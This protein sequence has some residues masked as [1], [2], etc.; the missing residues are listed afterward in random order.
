M[1]NEELRIRNLQRVL[2]TTYEQCLCHGIENTTQGMLV[3]ASGLSRASIDRYF[4]NKTDCVLQT[5]EWLARRVHERIVVWSES[6]LTGDSDG[7]ELLRLYLGEYKAAYCR[8]PQVFVLIAEMKAFIYRNCPDPTAAYTMLS[9]ALGSRALLEGILARG[10][11]DGSLS[12]D[13]S[14]G[15]DAMYISEFTRELLVNLALTRN[16]TSAEAERRIDRFID[17]MVSVYGA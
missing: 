16:P 13:I 11:E 4:V 9:N 7:R 17:K 3:R 12:R 15:D 1:A 10:V 8:Q 2:Q 5:A 14:L 6:A